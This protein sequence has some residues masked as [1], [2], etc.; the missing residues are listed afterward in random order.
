L[1]LSDLLEN[2]VHGVHIFFVISGFCLTWAFSGPKGKSLREFSMRAFFKHRFTRLAPAYY[3]V[4]ALSALPVFL[5]AYVKMGSIPEKFWSDL[6]AHVFFVHNLNIHHVS[7]F[8]MA[9]WTIALQLQF[10]LFF[11]IFLLLLFRWGPW[12]LTLVV[13]AAEVLYR[14]WVWSSLTTEWPLN[15]LMA[16]APPGRMF[17]F[18]SGMALANLI[19]NRLLCFESVRTKY[20]SLFLLVTSG[21]LAWQ[22]SRVAGRLHPAVDVLWAVCISA[23]IALAFAP[24]IWRRIMESD[25]LRFCGVCSYSIFLV[26][27]PIG[28]WLHHHFYFEGHIPLLAR[29]AIMGAYVPLMI[30]LGWI[31]YQW[32]EKPFL[33]SKEA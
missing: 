13:L 21:L 30:G 7:G 10:Y 32:L 33:R 1:D 25:L 8:N 31:C 5:A 17:E 18:V 24:G 22:L 26:H 11:P 3:S 27:H 29:L 20:L 16:Y 6:F 15:Y 28:L 12:G 14:L 2:G 19:R 4:L 23:G 9:L